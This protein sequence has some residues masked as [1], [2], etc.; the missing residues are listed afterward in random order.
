MSEPYS[1]C[2]TLAKWSAQCEV[3]VGWAHAETWW[4]KH[5]CNTC[6]VLQVRY[7]KQLVIF[8]KQNRNIRENNLVDYIGTVLYQFCLFTVYYQN[9]RLRFFTWIDGTIFSE[10]H[11][12]SSLNCK[13]SRVTQ[14]HLGILCLWYS[15]FCWRVLRKKVSSKYF[16]EVGFILRTFSMRQEFLTTIFT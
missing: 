5:N 3:H 6:V 12:N 10:L 1:T 8:F 7:C 2:V 4:D 11:K 14:G 15:K 16:V 9:N 13:A